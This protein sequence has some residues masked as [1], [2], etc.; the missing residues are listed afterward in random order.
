MGQGAEAGLGLAQ[1]HQVQQLQHPGVGFIRAERLVQMQD[2]GNL[3]FDGMQRV[4]GGQ[5]F[6]E[7]HGDAVAPDLT[8]GVGLSP[9][10]LLTLEGNAAAGMVGARIG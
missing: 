7:D 1:T 6:L 4:E 9:D 10:Q 2:L 8:H 5:R 3:L